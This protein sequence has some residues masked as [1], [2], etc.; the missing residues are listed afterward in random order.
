[1]PEDDTA[2]VRQK[3]PTPLSVKI[4]IIV[5]LAFG[6]VGMVSAIYS[7]SHGTYNP[8]PHRTAARAG[9][10]HA[11]TTLPV[12]PGTTL[13]PSHDNDAGRTR[14]PD[15]T[16]DADSDVSSPNSTC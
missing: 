3:S 11:T 5:A 4:L 7:S 12:G 16:P 15:A 6:A 1:M 14:L 13:P 10:L 9:G 2:P 8:C